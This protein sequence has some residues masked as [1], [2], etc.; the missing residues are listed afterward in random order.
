MASDLELVEQVRRGDVE[1]FGRLSTRYERSVLAIAL[2]SLR[3]M[4]AAEDVA[5][6][7]L[8]AAFQRL[9]TLKDGSKFGP[10][11]MRIA[12]RKVIDAMRCEKLPV[13][14][15]AELLLDA[16]LENSS[17]AVEHEHLLGLTARLPD[18]ERIVIGLR[19]FDG[20]STAEIA[21][22]TGKPIGS[23]TKQLSRAIARLRGWAEEDLP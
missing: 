19:Y 17:A 23:V 6:A 8:L 10:W 7:A 15:P 11:L 13:G 16:R 22:I 20:H 14:G 4:H 5:Q 21:A 12:R 1:A 18:H 3:D 9:N 2:V